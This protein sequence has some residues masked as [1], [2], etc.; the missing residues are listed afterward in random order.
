MGSITGSGR[1]PGVGNGNPTPVIW[2]ATVHGVSKS[3]T[4]L[5]THF[6]FKPQSSTY[7]QKM[8]KTGLE[9]EKLLP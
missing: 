3:W 9:E 7:L 1:F 4:Q 8:R 6:A 2:W 5:S